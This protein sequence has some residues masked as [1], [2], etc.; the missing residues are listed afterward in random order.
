MKNLLSKI[1][2]AGLLLPGVALAHTGAGDAHGFIHGFTHPIGGADHLLA[3]VAVGLWATQMG[4][5]A[6]WL[7]P[8]SFVLVMIMGGVVGF[9]NVPLPFI[10]QGILLSVLV[11]GVLIAGAFHFP[12]L[13]SAL[14]VG[15]FAIFHGYA[16]GAEMPAESG[17]FVYVAGFALATAL[18]HVS[19]IVPGLFIK[20]AKLQMLTR[21]AG[22]A[23][24]LSGVYLAIS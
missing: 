6:L 18:L 10:E 1:L 15:I 5:R 23:V 21:F 19:G 9:L 20:S 12:L 8:S 17:T 22:G 24:A 11:L 4:G 16:H 3:M 7:V 13:Y 2:L 14:L